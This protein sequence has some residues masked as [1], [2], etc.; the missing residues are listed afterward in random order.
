M[1]KMINFKNI[2]LSHILILSLALLSFACKKG[3]IIGEDPYAGGKQPLGIKF[4]N[5]LPEPD[6]AVQGGKVKIYVRGLMK[7]KDDFTL[8]VNQIKADV[9]SFTDSTAT[10][11]VPAD[12][13]T[14]GLSVEVKGQTFFG[15]VLQIEGKVS[16]DETFVT[17]GAT[18]RN[19]DGGSAQASVLDLSILPSGN[20]F[21][22]GS[23]NNFDNKWSE[24][25]PNGGIAQITSDG[26]YVAPITPGVNLGKGASGPINSI[27]RLT[28]GPHD[29]KY[30]I[31]GLFNNFISPIKQNVRVNMNSITRLTTDGKVD[32]MIID[33]I[34]PTPNN[35]YKNQDTVPAFNGGVDGFIRKS[36]VFGNRLYVIGSFKNYI[37]RFYERS[38]YDTKVLDFTR[39][40]QLACLK[41][42]MN[43]PMREGELDSTFHFDPVTRQSP[44]G[45]NGNINDAIQLPN[46]QLILTGSFTTFNGTAANRLVRLNLDG[47]VDNTFNVSGGADDEIYS[48]TYNATTNKILVSGLFK[49]FGGTVKQGVAM[50]NT[51]GSLV[52]SFDFGTITEG[53]PT[54]AAQLNSGKVVVSGNFKTYKGVVRQGFMILNADASL[55]AGYNNTGQFVGRINKIIESTSGGNTRLILAGTISRFDNRIYNGLVRIL[56]KN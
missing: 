20:M 7:F 13:S 18:Y 28:S 45:A 5:V 8:Y 41:I 29:G 16:V 37:R 2:R 22:V 47:S 24:K 48:I 54:F 46:G 17:Q 39:M 44:I 50:L 55:A 40:N 30:I 32:S 34:N 26:A 53:I 19:A 9:L 38:T 23:F 3:N 6:L 51:D 49:N 36:F 14:G 11:I 43:D 31:T 25:Q 21:V 12:A 15:P 42:N 56:L 33:V 52:S 10:I 35:L 1:K 4:D 27:S